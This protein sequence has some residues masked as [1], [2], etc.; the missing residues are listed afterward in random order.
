MAYSQ[1][2]PEVEPVTVEVFGHSAAPFVVDIIV[3][4][5]DVITGQMT[6]GQITIASVSGALM[7]RLES[8]PEFAM[9]F[10]PAAAEGKFD[11]DFSCAFNPGYSPLR[12][13]QQT[14]T[15]E[16]ASAA[17]NFDP[18]TYFGA[19]NAIF[20]MAFTAQAGANGL[21]WERREWTLQR[22]LTT[23][24][25]RIV[26]LLG[27]LFGAFVNCIVQLAALFMALMLVGS[28]ISG[29]LKLIWGTNIVNILLVVVSAALAACGM[30][31]LI[32]GLARTPEQGNVI[33]SAIT[34]LMALV[35]GAF[36][37]VQ[38]LQ[39]IPILGFLPYL[40]F[41][42]WGVDAFT[43]LSIG[44][45]DILPNVAILLGLGTV[46]FSIGLWLFNR[47]MDV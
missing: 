15:G 38:A 28:L 22:M 5:T 41:N 17:G 45:G 8:D 47:R 11:P 4:I 13:E 40:T 16:S 33:G 46:M 1:D 2:H 31:T 10:G 44:Q 3:N 6:T 35:G 37:P 19:A 24:T 34:I 14:I 26:V 23:P 18:L 42:Y 21:L 20:F 7:D 32:N 25:P 9:K 29:E 27:R 43:K 39:R 30:G 12:L 36:F